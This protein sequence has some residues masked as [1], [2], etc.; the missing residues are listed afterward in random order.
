M[1]KIVKVGE[2]QSGRNVR[3][4][5]STGKEVKLP[6]VKQDIKTGKLPDYEWVKPKDGRAPF[7]RAKPNN[8]KSDNIDEQPKF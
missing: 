5:Y 7:P 2:T 3:F 6:Q 4:K 1:T 8:K